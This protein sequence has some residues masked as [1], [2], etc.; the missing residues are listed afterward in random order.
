MNVSIPIAAL[1]FQRKGKG[2]YIVPFFLKDD[3]ETGKKLQK[4][5]EYYESMSG[6]KMVDFNE[7][8]IIEIMDDMKV[9]RAILSIM[10]RF[11]CFKSRDF[12][13]I[14]SS[15]EQEIL[16]KLDI[17]GADTL[18]QALFEY[19][20]D[21]YRGFAPE[22]KKALQE[23]R[24]KLKLKTGIGSALWVDCD[25][26]KLLKKI[27]EAKEIVVL[28]NQGV[29]AT[30]FLNSENIS[31]ALP[32]LDGKI[33]RKIYLLCKYNGV[34]CDI[35]GENNKYTLE[36]SGPVELFGKPEKYGYNISVAAFSIFRI[37][38]GKDYSFSS[39]VFIKNR[40]SVLFMGADDIKN[41][42]IGSERKEE[43]G[44]EFDSA[45]EEKLYNFFSADKQSWK[46]EREPEL[47]ITKSFVYVPDF[48][49]LRSKSRVYV[50]IMGYFTEHYQKK[51]IEKLKCIKKL[52]IP[53]IIIASSTY[54]DSIKK[55]IESIGYPIVYFKGK[56]IPYGPVLRVLEE[57][58]SDF[59]ERI[60][61]IEGEK[62]EIASDI[63]KE[64]ETAD[65]ISDALLKEKLKCF[66]DDEFEKCRDMILGMVKG[67][68]IRGA[69]LFSLKKLD[70]LKSIIEKAHSEKRDR[71]Y[72]KR[73]FA[74][75]G[76]DKVEPVL[77]HFGYAVKWR[78]LGKNEIVKRNHPLNS[79]LKQAQLKVK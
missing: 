3:N 23:F 41:T 68:H 8:I 18:R 22:R 13:E 36:I 76:V 9:G 63:E 51:K 67:T 50:E 70:D 19:V 66:T 43:T 49:Y 29:L 59:D 56:D 31:I 26:E 75:I 44:H 46:I 30:L 20:N 58:F 47:I 57:K 69:G 40:K 25:D 62:E 77:A 61:E 12:K 21:K 33:L 42:G 79:I 54:E 6:K 7:R 45:P 38:N 55:E 5:T 32:K 37:L 78:G 73:S 74:E 16:S 10:S 14:F 64:L 48:A 34:L 1:K 15:G 27:K 28:Y 65:F 39:N 17:C 71:E 52:N 24:N 60:C 35:S 4:I 11:Y 53:M 2:R 72:L